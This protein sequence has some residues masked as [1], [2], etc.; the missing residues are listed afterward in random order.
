MIPSTSSESSKPCSET[1][2]EQLRAHFSSFPPDASR[3]NPITAR[4]PPINAAGTIHGFFLM[5]YSP[6]TIMLEGMSNIV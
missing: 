6:F 5:R 1:S 3:A 2:L 4:E